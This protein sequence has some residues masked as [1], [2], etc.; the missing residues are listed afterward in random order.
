MFPGAK[1][2]RLN[3]LLSEEQRRAIEARSGVRVR[4]AELKVWKSSDGGLFIVDDVVGKHELITFALALTPA[5]AVR[6]I[7]ILDYR[8][9]YGYEVRNADWRAQFIGKTGGAALK[10]DQDIRNI[11]GATLSCRHV[12][13]GVKRLLVTYDVALK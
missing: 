8:E 9:S 4:S 6:A 10:L 7:E 5:G 13:D 2:D 1:L 11:S 12:T 3:L